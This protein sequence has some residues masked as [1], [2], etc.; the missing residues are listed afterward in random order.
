MQPDGFCSKIKTAVSTDAFR[1]LDDKIE[2]TLHNFTVLPPQPTAASS[3][4]DHSTQPLAAS[5]PLAE[6]VVAEPT[7]APVVTAYQDTPINDGVVDIGLVAH[8]A[9]EATAVEGAQETRGQDTSDCGRGDAESWGF[10]SPDSGGFMGSQTQEQIVRARDR[11]A[12]EEMVIPRTLPLRQCCSSIAASACCCTLS[13]LILC[14][15]CL[16]QVSALRLQ[17]DAQALEALLAAITACLPPHAVLP[18]DI[19]SDVL[20]MPLS[21][22]PHTPPPNPASIFLCGLSMTAPTHPSP[23]PFYVQRCAI[24]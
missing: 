17:R 14:L 11:K 23:P 2:L 10:K 1:H 8:A 13:I 5:E 6:A 12:D 9:P 22:E 4:A 16:L 7:A 19:C 3:D 24:A 15:C 18:P 20:T 21:S